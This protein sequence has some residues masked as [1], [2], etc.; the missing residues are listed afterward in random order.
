ML[1]F[2]LAGQMGRKGAGFMGFPYLSLAGP[3]GLTVASGAVSPSLALKLLQLQAMPEAIRLKLRGYTTEMILYE[4]GRKDYERGSFPSTVLTLYQQAGLDTL[5]G[6]SGD[7]DPYMKRP[8]SAFLDE[9]IE[10]GWQQTSDTPMRILIEDGGNLLRRTRGYPVLVDQLLPR[11]DLLVTIDWRMSHTA[12]YSDYVL[13]AASWYEKDDIT[14]ATPIS[15]FA[16]VITRAADPRGEAKS[17][18]E[19]HCRFMQ[20]I[21]KRAREREIRDFKDRSGS[22]RRFEGIYD[23]FTFGQRFTEHNTE[24]FLDEILSLTTNLGG[25]GW[26]ELSQKGFARYTGLGSGFLNIGNATDIEP[27]Q[28]ITANTWHTEKKQPWPTL[29]R[30]IQ[31]YIDHDFYMELGEELPIHKS[32]PAIGGNYPLQ[33][34]GGHT[35]WSIH[36]MWR[37][38][39]HMLQLNR[40]VP[41]GFMSVADAAA[42]KIRD[43]DRIRM[44]NDVD[45]CEL[46]AKVSAAL[47]PGQVSVYHAWEPFQFSGHKSH[48]ALTPSPINPLQLAG[49][50]FHL[51]PQAASGAPGSTD[52][53]TR[54]E[55]EK[56]SSGSGS[57][58]S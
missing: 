10:K 51:Q 50:Y 45:A 18:W 38:Q 41:V 2:V 5:Y 37:D 36:S 46:Q 19:I 4:L 21:E 7:W 27:D 49:G 58:L 20:R 54:I 15:P 32:P 13:P 28:T 34:V 29:T 16:Q 1:V 9:A 17:D 12:L 31:F 52:R 30:R 39:K 48:A 22:V 26:K 53:G 43:G 33:L 6:R 14:W 42:R 24:A 8:L 57:G 40:G 44:F 3:A 23:E 11:L 56:I 25:I 35:R 47:R 55:I